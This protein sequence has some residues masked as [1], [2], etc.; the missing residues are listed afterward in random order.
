[1]GNHLLQGNQFGLQPVDTLRQA[2]FVGLH[3]EVDHRIE[4]K[5]DLTVIVPDRFRANSLVRSRE[6]QLDVAVELHWRFESQLCPGLGDVAYDA[7][8][9][10]TAIEIPHRTAQEAA[11]SVGLPSF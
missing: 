1:P 6:M 2:L 3:A 7:G 5:T 8:N 4:R 10:D 9:D 11:S